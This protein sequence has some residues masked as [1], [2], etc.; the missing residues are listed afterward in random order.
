M[1]VE[2]GRLC[3]IVD[4]DIAER[5]GW[6]PLDLAAAYLNGGA[7]FLQLRAKSLPGAELLDLASRLRERA[8]AA[9]ACLIINDR[10]D[11]ARL[12]GAAGVHLGQDDLPATAARAI[13]GEA[14]VLGLSTHSREQIERAVLAPVTYIAIGPVFGTTTKQT[15]YEAV[16]L[17]R[18][19]DASNRAASRGISVVAIGGITLECAPDVIDAGAASVDY[20][21]PGRWRSGSTCPCLSRSALQ[22][23]QGIIRE[24]SAHE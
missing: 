22:L 20:G 12:S 15:G 9:G 14:A 6:S 2:F 8:D 21:S 24:D 18:V 7:R 5:A 13:V 16:G 10:A 19:R 23:E 4:V 3:A 11:I 1:N 17:A